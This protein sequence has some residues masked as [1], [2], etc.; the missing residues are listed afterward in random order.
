MEKTI[1]LTAIQ[2]AMERVGRNVPL[3]RKEVQKLPKGFHPTSVYPTPFQ[4][5]LRL[6]NVKALEGRA[7]KQIIPIW[8]KET[9][10]LKSTKTIYHY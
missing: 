1:P 4:K 8:D 3:T 7:K 5:Q 9:G 2:R 10:K 6:N